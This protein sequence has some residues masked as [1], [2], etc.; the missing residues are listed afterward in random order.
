[1]ADITIPGAG[2]PTGVV[3]NVTSV[4]NGVLA[5]QILQTLGTSITGGSIGSTVVAPGGHGITTPPTVAAGTFNQLIIDASVS[6]TTSLPSSGY[7]Y[8]MIGQAGNTPY[9]LQT[10]TLIGTQ[11]AP[12]APA[13]T[14]LSSNG[15][16]TFYGNGESFNFIGGGNNLI[17]DATVSAPGAAINLVSD[18][19]SGTVYG[20][21][22]SIN[23]TFNGGANHYFG[24]DGAATI[25]TA[26]ADTIALNAGAAT[27][28]LS[29]TVSGGAGSI[30]G[31]SG[32]MVVHDNGSSNAQSVF[33]SSGAA[34]VQSTTDRLT[35]FG[36]TGPTEFDVG[37]GAGT[38]YGSSGGT[39]TIFG[40]AGGGVFYPNSSQMLFIAGTGA[41]TVSGGAVGSTIFGN[42]GSSVT[43]FGS[44]NFANANNLIVA[45]SGNETLNAYW[46]VGKDTI[47]AGSGNA[48]IIGGFG[49]DTFIGGSGSSTF[50][51]GTGA[52]VFEFQAAS[53]GGT[54][55]ISQ[56]NVNLDKI[57]LSGYAST[58]ASTAVAGQVNAGGSTT[59]TLSDST[60]IT[61][62]GVSR[63]D[64]TIFK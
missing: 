7:Q 18:T 61:F 58:Q 22:S 23:A 29:N 24:G 26:G 1:M 32:Q 17:T 54:D 45:G 25:N 51:A 34:T 30:F 39:E 37:S 41:A 20:G 49:A 60:K 13:P 36:G 14:V 48:S 5:N 28:N 19:G 12:G 46:S 43:Y 53:V 38:F 42:A 2:S 27:I 50:V 10:Q 40:G 35:F 21:T 3:I 63:V 9:A 59:I 16:V 31:G 55:V 8:L 64:S 6:G 52:N 44:Q 56:F 15:G 33:G 47:I 57:A 4:Q 11:Q 62:L